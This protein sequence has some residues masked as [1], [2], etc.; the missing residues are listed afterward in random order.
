MFG[1]CGLRKTR[2]WNNEPKQQELIR[3]IVAAA[4]DLSAYSALTKFIIQASMDWSPSE[5]R[6]D[7]GRFHA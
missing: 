7:S 2:E 4:Q 5:T 1:K 3:L 6:A